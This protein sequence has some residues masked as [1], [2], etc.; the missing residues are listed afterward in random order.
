MYNVSDLHSE[1]QQIMTRKLDA[2]E[3]INRAWITHEIL[4]NHPL[5]SFDGDDFYICCSRETV[6]AHV[7]KVNARFKEYPEEVAGQGALPLEGYSHLQR[8]YPIE[9]GGEL[10]IVPITQMTVVEGRQKAGQYR[11]M[12]VGVSEHADE[13]DRFFRGEAEAAD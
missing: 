3:I 9:R 6:S 1:I 4:L 13:L 5:V 12:A 10:L 8:A 11:L 7:K 2:G